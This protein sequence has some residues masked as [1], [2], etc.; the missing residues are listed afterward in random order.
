MIDQEHYDFQRFSGARILLEGV[1]LRPGV[2]PT[3][4]AGRKARLEPMIRALWDL[5]ERGG[6]SLHEVAAELYAAADLMESGQ[7]APLQGIT[8]TPEVLREIAEYVATWNVGSSARV[9]HAT[10]TS[11]ELAF[12]MPQLLEM[13]VIYYG[14]DGMA[15]E[16]DSLSPREGL[17]LAVDN[18]HPLCLWWLPHMAAECQEALAVF[19]TE[20]ALERFFEVEHAVGTPGLPW[21]EWLPLIIDVFGEHMRAQHPPRWVHTSR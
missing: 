3:D 19:Q 8:G 21:L 9:V 7:D 12:R 20:E 15:L 5:W 11:A 10:P 6:R 14:Q 1:D 17:H 18:Y 13:L 16:D 4:I 2:V